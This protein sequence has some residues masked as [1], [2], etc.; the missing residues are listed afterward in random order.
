[1]EYPLYGITDGRT[2]IVSRGRDKCDVME[3][4][5]RISPSFPRGVTLYHTTAL[6]LGTNKEYD[7]NHDPG[8]LERCPEYLSKFIQG[9][10]CVPASD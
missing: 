7:K 9:E 8:W 3:Y 6:P 5:A 10:S 4:I 1:M 2:L